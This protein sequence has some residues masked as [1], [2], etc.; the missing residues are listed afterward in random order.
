MIPCGLHV[1]RKAFASWGAT[2]LAL[3]DGKKLV[4]LRV[5]EGERKELYI[6]PLMG[7]NLSDFYKPLITFPH[8]P[9]NSILSPDSFLPPKNTTQ[10]TAK[11]NVQSSAT[12]A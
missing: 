3:F 6:V 9:Q 5:S 2:V 4:L 12:S 10:S 8:A 11:Q 1:S 7:L